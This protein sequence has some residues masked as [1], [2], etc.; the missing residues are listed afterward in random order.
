MRLL[1]SLLLL[2][3]LSAQAQAQAPRGG[4]PPEALRACSGRSDGSA[5]QFQAPHGRVQGQC[6]QVPGGRACVPAMG[7]EG[8]GHAQG[9]MPPAGGRGDRPQGGGAAREQIPAT[10]PRAVPVLSRVPDT[11]QGGCYDDRGRIDCPGPGMP[12]HGQDAQYGG[13][14]PSYRETDGIVIDE[15]TGLM[16]QQGHN[17]RRL[18]WRDAGAACSRLRLGGFDDWRLPSIRELFSIADFRGAVGIRPYLDAR[19][20]IEEPDASIL[21]GDPFAA[22][23]RTEMMGQTWSATIYQGNHWDRPGLEAAFFM[24]FLD[25][26]IKQ[27]PID[28]RSQLFY[29]CVR[30]QPWGKNELVDNGD[31]S[32]T[33]H[34]SGL[35]WQQTDDGERR[36]WKQ[37]L[38]YCEGLRLAGRED[39]RLPNIKELQSLVDYG[40]AA[41]ALDTRVLGQR[42]P[43][44]WFWSSTSH[45]DNLTQA[46]YICFGRCTS[47]EGVDVHG[48]GAQRSDPKSAVGR[49]RSHQGGQRD[50]VRVDNYARCVR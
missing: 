29:R 39:W 18:G 15:V 30:G 47:A 10:G 35:T 48:A 2:V 8:R 22:T 4:P 40:R 24:N 34:F 44:G 6:R 42:D 14:A 1:M 21:R 45:G 50:E 7:G 41:P 31:G 36:D 25:G 17:A 3:V 33:D 26:H 16:W 37:A 11:N 28:G 20:R 12:F 27:A 5:C 49:V 32:V 23:H 38:A 46:E 43:A 13:A 19:F 9:P